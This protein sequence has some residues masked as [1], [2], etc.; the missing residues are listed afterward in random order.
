[1]NE[2]SHSFHEK[3]LRDGQVESVSAGS[4]PLCDKDSS[5][6]LAFRGIAISELKN[7]N[8]LQALTAEANGWEPGGKLPFRARR[9]WV[10]LKAELLGLSFPS[11][12]FS[13][14]FSYRIL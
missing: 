4:S 12:N 14:Y 3:E 11:L 13:H 5:A 10:G 1:M 8:I 9:A 7:H 6:L 2:N